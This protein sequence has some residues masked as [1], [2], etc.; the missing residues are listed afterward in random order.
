MS[1]WAGWA[2]IAALVVLAALNV[3]KLVRSWRD[4]TTV[5]GAPGSE[6]PDFEA[7]LLGGGKFHLAAE[8]GHPVVLVFWASWCAP[9][10]AELPGVEAL[11]KQRAGK[12]TRIVAVNVENDAALAAEGVAQLHL[13]LPVALED[14]SASRAFQVQTIPMTVLVKPDGNVADVLRG[15]VSEDALA[16]AIDRLEA[17]K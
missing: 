8:R 3:T 14:G 12:P 9:C 2:V 7:P 1:R 4:V 11:A 5:S 17:A 13:T 10:R 16:R 15:S 6:A